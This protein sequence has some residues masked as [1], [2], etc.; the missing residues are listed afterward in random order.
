[1]KERE[2][3]KRVIIEGVKPEIDCGRFPIKRTIG[4]RVSVEADIFIEGHEALSAVLLYRKEDDPTWVEIPMEPLVNDRWRGSFAVTQLGRYRYTLTAWSDR[5]KSWRRDLS[6]KVQAGLDVSVDLLVGAQ[7]I[8]EAGQ[9]ASGP[10]AKT[11]Q[12][13]ANTL[14]LMQVPE[15]AR[16]EL[17]L[18]K[19]VAG[20]MDRYPDRRVTT[21]YEKELV[22]VVDREKARFSTWYEMFP[23]ACASEPGRHGT[24]KDCDV[25]LPYIA[26]MGFDVLYFPPIHPIGHTHRKGK[27]SAP[28]AGPEDCGSP[29]GIGGDEGGHKAVH[30]QLGSLEDFRR[31]VTKAREYGIEVALDICPQRL[32]T[33]P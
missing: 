17:G 25:R 28:I 19:D 1:M 20:L 12:G 33:C 22:V 7:V 29:W 3:R 26:G 21:T 23:R 9:R 16:V 15:A 27:N 13:W 24:F 30:P 32:G 11:L 31:F 8:G 4:E 6:K 5:F 10:E 2:G 14:C 18:S